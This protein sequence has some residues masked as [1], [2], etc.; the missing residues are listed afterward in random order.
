MYLCFFG[1]VAFIAAI[2][3]L[4]ST[5]QKENNFHPAPLG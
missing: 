2:S 1:L 5:S 4:K 3:A